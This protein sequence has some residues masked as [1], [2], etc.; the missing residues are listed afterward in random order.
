MSER[1]TEQPRLDGP[2]TAEPTRIRLQVRPVHWILGAARREERN[3]SD[4]DVSHAEEV[5]T[6]GF[7]HGAQARGIEVSDDGR[8]A[9]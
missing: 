3:H 4:L 6:K 9:V 5:D 2:L 8:G 1:V 7:I